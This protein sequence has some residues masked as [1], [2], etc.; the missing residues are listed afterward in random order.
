MLFRL[1]ASQFGENI[2]IPLIDVSLYDSNYDSIFEDYYWAGATE[3]Q[4]HEA[5]ELE[6]IELNPLGTLTNHHSKLHNLALGP[7]LHD[8][9]M[10]NRLNDPEAGAFTYH[11]G[12]RYYAK[13]AIRAGSELF[14]NYG[15]NWWQDR[16]AKFQLSLT[17]GVEGDEQRDIMKGVHEQTCAGK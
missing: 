16:I 7:G 4:R 15:E 17:T 6:M 5:F 1:S 11:G 8:D 10:V 3:H 12:E 13:H 2:A 9:T 14:N